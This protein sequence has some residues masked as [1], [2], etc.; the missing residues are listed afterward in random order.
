MTNSAQTVFLHD[1]SSGS[2]A[3]ILP[4]YG[5]N[6]VSF[7]PVVGGEP[8][9]VIWAEEGFGPGSRPSR[10]GIPLLF[11]FAGRLR[12]VEFAFQERTYRVEGAQIN[13]GNAIHGFVLN[14]PWRVV[15]QSAS[16]VT[17]EFQASVDDPTLVGQWPADFRVAVTYAVTGPAL[18]CDVEIA[19]PDD[20]PLPFAFGTHP[21]FRV[22]LGGSD[23]AACTVT[24]PASTSWE[25]DGGIPTGPTEPVS[26]MRDLRKGARFGDLALDAVLTDLASANGA[27]QTV[28]DDPHSGRRLTQTFP[29]AFPHV[30]VYIAPHREA[31]A[32]EPYTCIPNPFAL[33]ARGIDTGLRL[34][35]PGET[36]AARIEIRLD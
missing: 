21:Y 31:I 34:L 26:G 36:F 5:F 28:I 1:K 6:C 7:K 30:V 3:T 29:D 18:T 9:E 14:R 12:G 15:D 33:E 4:G 16:S 2:E 13:D 25:L 20:K 35:Q 11:P 23:R 32:V 17:G 27:I 19:N 22:P 24:V 10:S 8:I